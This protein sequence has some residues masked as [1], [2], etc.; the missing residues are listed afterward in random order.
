MNPSAD[1]IPPPPK[2]TGLGEWLRKSW[3]LHAVLL[4]LVTGVGAVLFKASLHGLGHRV[5]RDVMGVHAPENPRL[6]G[7]LPAA[8]PEPDPSHPVPWAI[9]LLPALGGLLSG[10]LCHRFAPEAMGH[11]T[12]GGIHAF[13]HRQGIVRPQV[14]LVKMLASTLTLGFGGSGGVEGPITQIGSGFGSNLGQLLRL[15][16]R[17]TRILLVAGMGAGLAAL[18]EAP[19]AA[20][21]F[22]G[23][24][25]YRGSDIDGE[26]IIPS[27][28]ASVVAYSSYVGLVSVFSGVVRWTHMFHVPAWQFQSGIE[29]AGYTVLAVVCA[30]AARL[31]IRVFYGVE[32]A[33]AALPVPRWFRPACGGLVTGALALATIDLMREQGAG[34]GL[35]TGVL[36]GGDGFLQLAI[37]SRL[38]VGFL[39]TL[40]VLK[41]LATSASVGSGGSAGI[42]GPSLI[43]GGLAGGVVGKVLAEVAPGWVAQPGSYALI[44]MAALFGAAAHA[45]LASI[46]MVAEVTRSYGLLVPSIWTCTL[47]SIL[48]GNRSLYSQQVEH[49]E[50]SPAH[51]AEMHWNVLEDMPCGS[52]MRSEV[53]TMAESAG[54]AQ[55]EKALLH[56][57][58]S[59]FPVLDARGD[60]VG[61]ITLAKVREVFDQPEIRDILIAKDAMDPVTASAAPG[62]SLA[63]ALRL[64]EAN[65]WSLLCVTADG[66]PRKLVGVVSRSDI[67]REYGVELR[68]RS[69]ARQAI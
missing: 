48:V 14:P 61:V 53:A 67:L 4:G 57:R 9:L 65:G 24:I 69:L 33:F 8:H 46:I 42:F 3:I 34:F 10:L 44:G 25:L 6:E 18:F 43:L 26:V 51:R 17:R 56:H 7:S 68:R 63:E 55:I 47:A 12:D 30:L 36:D 28:I 45:P 39:A 66:D 62:T 1:P 15:G 54:Y 50:D 41:M 5:I 31:W 19:L 21:L 27:A 20:T 23:E 13:H 22:A 11:G 49:L 37:D 16:D 60:L 2:L 32:H 59:K 58:H 35:G 64:M 38:S 40:F 52:V 29:L